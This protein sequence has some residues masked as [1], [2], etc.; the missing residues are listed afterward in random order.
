MSLNISLYKVF[1]L[2]IA[3]VF[4]A[5]N[6]T[7]CGGGGGGAAA[8]APAPADTTPPT[9]ISSYPVNSATAAAATVP[10]SATFSES[11]NGAT[12]LPANFTLSGGVLGAVTYSGTTATFTPSAPLAY[13][14]TYT[15]TISTGVKDLAGNAMAASKTWTFITR[16]A[17]LPV[18]VD[19][20]LAATQCNQLGTVGL[21]A[22][23][24]VPASTLSATQDGMLGRDANVLT[25][26]NADGKLGF[27]FATVT[28]GCVLDN[29]T[30]LMW[31]VK[32]VDGGLRDWTKTYTN[33]DSTTSAQKLSGATYVNPTQADIDAATNSRGFVN[34]V[35]ALGL[36]GYSDW[37]LPSA[38]ELLS[39]VD[40]G[41]AFPGPALD[42]TWFLNTQ[43]ATYWTSSPYV[44]STAN[45][46]WRIDFGDGYV[47]GDVLNLRG[48]ASYVRLVRAGL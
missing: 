42:A 21:V 43:A 35:N 12:L 7:A 37:R 39:L 36:C 11:M 10:I 15:A 19:T 48:N 4:V 14:T 20:G 45:F 18:N 41:V 2:G 47:G 1:A 22:C 3:M 27:S 17:P 29:V 13:A 6:F 30:G 33:F 34:D 31:E 38:D 28:G 44:A 5:L 46:A 26:S 24:L 9:V 25:N 23:N 40:Y 16:V 32:T 8:P